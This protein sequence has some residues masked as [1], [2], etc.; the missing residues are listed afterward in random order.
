MIITTAGPSIAF[1]VLTRLIPTPYR[2]GSGGSERLSD[3]LKATPLVSGGSGVEPRQPDPNVCS[4][5]PKCTVS[6]APDA[7][8][9]PLSRDGVLDLG[10]ISPMGSKDTIC[11]P[12]FQPC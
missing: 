11:F 7:V 8:W 4:T 12:S 5:P 3:F 6:S 2:R 9:A 10:G 1:T